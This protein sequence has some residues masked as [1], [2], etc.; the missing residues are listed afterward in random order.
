MYCPVEEVTCMDDPD[1][2]V[3]EKLEAFTVIDCMTA[4]VP[5]TLSVTP[6]TLMIALVV[7]LTSLYAANANTGINKK[8]IEPENRNL[9]MMFT[10]S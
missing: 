6:P 7:K 3:K 4:V 10:M 2:S 1:T 8:T 5:D 9:F